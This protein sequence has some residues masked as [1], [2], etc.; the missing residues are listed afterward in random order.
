MQERVRIGLLGCG[1][2]GGALVRLVHDHAD[3]IEARAGVP[4]EVVR[5]A[6]RDLDEGSWAPAPVPL[7]HRRRRFGGR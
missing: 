2:V 3:V 4:L 1:N 7:F 5:V 6:V